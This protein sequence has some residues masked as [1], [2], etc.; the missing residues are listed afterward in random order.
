[1]VISFVAESALQSLASTFFGTGELAAVN[2]QSTP[3]LEIAGLLAWKTV[4]IT[5]YWFGGFDGNFPI[6]H[7]SLKP[8]D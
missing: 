4:L 1:M 7:V 2:K 3:T 8:D 6:C 5:F